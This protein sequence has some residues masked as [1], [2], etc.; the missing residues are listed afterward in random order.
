[1]KRI[2]YLYD[3]MLDKEFIKKII[4]QAS[5]RKTKRKEVIRVL[6]NIDL[7]TDKIYKMLV[8]KDIQLR[9]THQRTIKEKG[10]ERLITISPFYPNQILDY[11]LVELTKPIIR[12][13]MYTYCIGNVDKRGIHY[14]KNYIEKNIHN[15]TYYIKLDI[16]HFYQNVRKKLLVQ[17]FEKKIKDKQF[18]WFINQI[19]AED[20]PIGCYYSQWFSNFFLCELDH[21]VKERCGIEC[22][23]RYVDDIVMC[24]NN[25]RKLKSTRYF[26]YKYLMTNMLE[27]KYLPSVRKINTLS[28]ISFIGFKFYCDKVMLRN[29]IFKKLNEAIKHISKHICSKLVK[30]A[31]NYISWLRHTTYGY[32]YY[33]KNIKEIIKFG[34][35]RYMA[36]VCYAYDRDK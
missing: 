21:L 27:L 33:I 31:L 17:C 12:K 18:I 22:Y 13:S 10:K 1:M 4:L 11:M 34:K 23:I 32:A 2:G 20:L 35:L 15:Y 8:T 29:K 7:Y 16:R 3:K 9:P 6:N 19:I 25:Q 14:G 28:S 24:S 30:R 36:S 26:V 5:K